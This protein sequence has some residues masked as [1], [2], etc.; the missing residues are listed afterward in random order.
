MRTM[1][2]HDDIMTV[3]KLLLTQARLNINGMRVVVS[4]LITPVPKI[5][6]RADFKWCSDEFR[7]NFNQWLLDEFGTKEVAYMISGG[8]IVISPCMANVLRIDTA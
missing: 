2:L 4:P 6:I 7:A 8:T 1:N 3:D 5:Q